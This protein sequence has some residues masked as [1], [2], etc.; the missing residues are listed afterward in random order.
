MGCDI[1]AYIEYSSSAYKKMAEERKQ[2]RHWRDFA[3]RISLDRNYVLFGL[4]SK[5]VRTEYPESLEAKG[6]PDMNELAMETK[7][8]LCLFVDDECYE[9][10]Y[11]N[12][13]SKEEAQ[14][15]VDDGYSEFLN[16]GTLVTCPDWHSHSWLTTEEFEIVLNNYK[17]I[18]TEITGYI[19][20]KFDNYK[21]T[22]A[23][24]KALQ[25]NDNDVR[26]VFWFDN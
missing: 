16:N 23:A 4:L 15:W 2:P 22:L 10:G 26:L 9:K 5:G 12:Y 20:D 17:I 3:K 24:M 18:K 13:I 25:E 19:D 8:E 6:L 11:E 1:H 7:F 21:A 14:K